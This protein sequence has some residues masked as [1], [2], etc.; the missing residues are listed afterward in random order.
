M[1]IEKLKE[2][3]KMNKE[4]FDK[5]H[6]PRPKAIED[7]DWILIYNSSLE[8]QHSTTKKFVKGW[9]GPYI[10]KRAYNNGRYLLQE[11]NGTE[12]KVPI[13]VKRIKLFK[14]RYEDICFNKEQT[15]IKDIEIGVEDHIEDK[16]L[17]RDEEYFTSTYSRIINACQKMHRFRGGG[18]HDI[19]QLIG[20]RV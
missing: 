14:Q 1:A 8:N 13:A 3:R 12:L 15:S 11:L 6:R 4:G 10:F 16:E 7:G 9:L 18:C 19:I 17:D 2:A 5:K 20:D